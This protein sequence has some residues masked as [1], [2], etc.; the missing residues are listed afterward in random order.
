[1]NRK[2]VLHIISTLEKVIERDKKDRGHSH[3]D[4]GHWVQWE[5]KPGEITCG[6]TAC[7]LGWEATTR[8]ANK[9]GLRLDDREGYSSE[10]DFE[11]P[12]DA[13]HYAFGSAAG[14]EYLNI[15]NQIAN[16]LF[17]P[18]YYSGGVNTKPKHVI[19][20]LQRLL[21]VG[22]ENIMKTWSR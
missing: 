7:A 22:E 11:D 10:V 2:N 18:E 14:A 1:M 6:T 19:K 16:W 13:C 9:R 20:R 4:M 5:G 8:Y 21:K 17:L 15:D 12:E 3:F